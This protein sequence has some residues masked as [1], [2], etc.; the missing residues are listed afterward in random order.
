VLQQHREVAHAPIEH[1]LNAFEAARQ[2][3]HRAEKR[4]TGDPS[5]QQRVAAAAQRRRLPMA[6][7]P[8]M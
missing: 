7:K 1:G 2:Q 5:F 6:R 3:G 8:A 4:G